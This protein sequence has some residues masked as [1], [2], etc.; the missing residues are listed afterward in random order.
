[1]TQETPAAES[2]RSSSTHAGGGRAGGRKAEEKKFIE[3]RINE[4]EEEELHAKVCQNNTLKN[5]HLGQ[6]SLCVISQR[7]VGRGENESINFASQVCILLVPAHPGF[8]F[9]DF[10]FPHSRE[11]WPFFIS[12]GKRPGVPEKS[13]MSSFYMMGTSNLVLFFAFG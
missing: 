9:R 7:F 2:S 11:S 6:P 4:R 10:S 5:K 1:M 3:N 12:R 13:N 8:T